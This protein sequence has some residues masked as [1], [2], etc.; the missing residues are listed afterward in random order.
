MH[1]LR[2]VRD[3]NGVWHDTLEGMEDV[4]WRSR[5]GIWATA[6]PVPAYGQALLGAYFR[7]RHAAFPS[8]PEPD[9]AELMGVVLT[10]DGGAPGA[11]GEP[12]EVYH[13]GARFT[14]CVLG[15]A[16]RAAAMGERKLDA[17]LERV[18]IH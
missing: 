14:A 4:L 6:P 10:P 7:T 9:W 16:L 2:G 3:E 11:D 17:A 18:L 13:L 5:R 12:Y 8:C 15:Q 1:S